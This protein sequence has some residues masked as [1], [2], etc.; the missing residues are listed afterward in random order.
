MR[1]SAPGIQTPTIRTGAVTIDLDG[2]LVVRSAAGSVAELFGGPVAALA[3]RAFLDLV[4]PSDRAAVAGA[5]APSFAAAVSRAG[6]PL[7]AGAPSLEFRVGDPQA[8]VSTWTWVALNGTSVVVPDDPDGA[9]GADG[10]GG[11]SLLLVD[12]DRARTAERDARQAKA[13]LQAVLANMPA[14][15][16]VRDHTGRLVTANREYAGLL[17]ARPEQ[18]VGRTDVAIEDGE[19][20]A[21]AYRQVLE[22]GR[23]RVRDIAATGPD[24]DAKAYAMV[25][26]PVFGPDGEVTAVGEIASDVTELRSAQ[27]SD[28]ERL[29]GSEERYRLLAEHSLDVIARMRPNGTFAYVSPAATHVLGFEPE[30]LTSPHGPGGRVHPE[31]QAVVADAL[32]RVEAGGPPKTLAYRFLHGNGDW[33]WLETTW[34]AIADDDTGG[35]EIFATTRDVSERYA[36]QQQ[37]E[38]LALR[39]GLTGLANRALLM[40]RLST[41]LE[42]LD[43]R[44][45]AVAVFLLDLD[46]FK[47]INDTYG[48]ACGD[49]VIVEAARRLVRASR[50]GDTVARLG[51]DELILVAEV[52]DRS[53]AELLGGRL[54][55]ELRRAYAEPVGSMVSASI[56]LAL[57]QDCR[58]DPDSL[59]QQAD[60]ALY[61]AKQGGRNRLEVFAGAVRRRLGRRR[62]V[63]QQVRSALTGDGLR[64]HYQAVA[65]LRTGSVIAAEALARLD[66]PEGL[67]IAP[68]I[69]IGVAEE[70]GLI[71]D[72]DRWVIRNVVDEVRRLSARGSGRCP[73]F[74]INVSARTLAT[75]GFA[76][77]LSDLLEEHQLDGAGFLLELTE[78][79]LLVAGE[80]VERTLASLAELGV[81]VGLDDFGTGWSSLRY[82]SE[83]SLDFVKLD[84]SF[85]AELAPDSRKFDFAKAVCGLASA[86]ELVVVAEGIE[87]AAQVELLRAAGCDLGQG[88]ALAR[89]GP[90][91]L[92]PRSVPLLR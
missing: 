53:E 23:T 40:D 69:F 4:H 36:A 46:R 79:T 12:V 41:A 88:Y 8:E 68:E 84:R 19:A 66:S 78:R 31:D 43:R 22:D 13:L 48:H 65:D 24:G 47:A 37:L 7:V 28:R 15:L 56:G 77:W 44:G 39:D 64:L 16:S 89:P 62:A 25:R 5:L 67:P 26:F 71:A 83:L 59:L 58:T 90:I 63:E 82:L 50:S 10:A 3:G 17:D 21:A 18:L 30:E 85:T 2:Q 29:A 45:G 91:S 92:L 76:D 74:S 55:K 42:R 14:A 81:G 11:R 80:T 54:L 9:G 52:S 87:N 70:T 60:V 61:A 6:S 38:K 20:A 49:A 57:A 73:V 34:S 1:G 32:S 33:R 35:Y 72:L 51:G 75:P 27:R 86:L